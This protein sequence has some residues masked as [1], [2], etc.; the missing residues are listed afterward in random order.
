MMSTKGIIDVDFVFSTASRVKAEGGVRPSSLRELIEVSLGDF[1]DQFDDIIQKYRFAH[2]KLAG[3]TRE[4]LNEFRDKMSK[5]DAEILE[6]R[7]YGHISDE[8]FY[9][10]INIQGE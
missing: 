9:Y 5:I 1:V 3:S 6:M 7:Y 8:R 10:V 4:Q 2:V